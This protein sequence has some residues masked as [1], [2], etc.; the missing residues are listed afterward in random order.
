M[1]Y[2][3]KLKDKTSSESAA[4]AKGDALSVRH[5]LSTL[6]MY[7]YLMARFGAPNGIQS[8]LR[9]DDS[10]N[11][12]HWDFNLK[13]GAAD[14][15]I[16]ATSRE[17]HF[18][19]AEPM[20]DADW[21]ALILALKADFARVGPEKKTILDGLEKW[22]LFPNKYVAIAGL[23]ADHHAVITDVLAGGDPFEFDGRSAVAA[24]RPEDDEPG[25]TRMVESPDAALYGACLQLALL[26]PIMAEAFIN[27]VIL[28]LCRPEVR[29][30]KRRYDAFIREQIDL[31]IAD[32]SYKCRGFATAVDMKSDVAKAFKR[33]M[34]KRNNSIHGN[35]DP[36]REGIETVYFDGKRPLYPEGGDHIGKFKA[37]LAKHYRPLDAVADYEATHMML[38]EIIEALEPNLQQQLWTILGDAYPGYDERRQKVGKLFPDHYVGGYLQGMRYDDDLEVEW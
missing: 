32:L 12:V 34:D 31:K 30:D 7:C 3:G 18:M 23:C 20:A 24:H 25:K 4:G 6:D 5:H 28:V 9:R 26:T 21:K 19:I 27:M 10:D 37:S 33:V 2:V 22:S 8:F 38:V 11:L 35:I 1:A 17:V 29:T 13:A 36:V 15:Y 16:I 14:V